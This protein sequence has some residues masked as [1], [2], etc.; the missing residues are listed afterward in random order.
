MS[1]PADPIR[2]HV[3]VSGY[4][5]G[6][7][8]RFATIS[9]AEHAGVAGWVRNLEDRRVEAVFEGQPAAVQALVEWC[10]HG[11]PGA[12]VRD[13]RVHWDEPLE[14]LSGF[15]ALPTAHSS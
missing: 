1:A 2:A 4:V 14:H 11:P 15:R 3:F 13:L 9:E 8:F 12:Y 5:Q 10:R 6:V 7:G